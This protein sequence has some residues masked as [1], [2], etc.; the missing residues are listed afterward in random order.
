MLSNGNWIINLTTDYIGLKS[1]GLD[2][3]KCRTFHPELISNNKGR[4]FDFLF[5]K[6]YMLSVRSFYQKRRILTLKISFLVLKIESLVNTFAQYFFADGNG[7]S[8]FGN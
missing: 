7:I 2:P 3:G 1:H 6:V 5:L 4:E 8:N